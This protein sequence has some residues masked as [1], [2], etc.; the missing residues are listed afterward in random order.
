MVVRVADGRDRD[1]AQREADEEEGAQQ[2][3]SPAERSAPSQCASRGADRHARD[4]GETTTESAPSTASALMTSSP[5]ASFQKA[6]NSV[7]SSG[8]TANITSW[9]TASSAY[10]LCTLSGPLRTPGHSARSPPSSGGVARPAIEH[11]QSS[12]GHGADA[13]RR[14]EH[15]ARPESIA[16]GNITRGCPCMSTSR[17]SSGCPTAVASPYTADSTPASV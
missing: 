7:S 11:A 13:D 15:H 8:P 1:G 5:A 4:G 3:S 17:P 14:E 2:A 10:A 9:A 12:R 16:A 6:T